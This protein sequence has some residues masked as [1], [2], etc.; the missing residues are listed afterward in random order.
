MNENKTHDDPAAAALLRLLDASTPDTLEA[1]LDEVAPSSRPEL[2]ALGMLAYDVE[3]VVV[4]DGLRERI[5]E[6]VALSP[7]GRRT[8]TPFEPRVPRSRDDVVPTLANQRWL[9]VLAAVL[10]FCVLGL[11]KMSYDLHGDLGRQRALVSDQQASIDRLEA[12]VEATGSSGTELA[13]MR[14]QLDMIESRFGIVTGHRTEVC[15]LAPPAGASSPLPDARAVL[16]VAADRQR[17]YLKA[18]G[19]EPLDGRV[20]QLWF[21]PHGGEPVSAGTFTVV[22]DQ[23]ELS[24]EQMPEN[25][26]AVLVTLELEPTEKPAGPVVLYGDEA[27]QL[28]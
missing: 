10:A 18:R 19:L 12:A 25:T 8:V 27:M 2:E 24:S 9:T 20:Y 14:R 26:R 15:A 6:R 23:I 1:A 3:P 5:L 17:W 11:G 4:S 28:L 21:Q 13:S 16:Y 22:A 7:G